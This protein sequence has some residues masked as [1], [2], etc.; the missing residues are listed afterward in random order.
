MTCQCDV[1]TIYPN[2]QH[3]AYGIP[4]NSLFQILKLMFDCHVHRIPIIDRVNVRFREYSLVVGRKSNW[5]NQLFGYSPLSC[6]I[7]SRISP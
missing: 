5:C 4:N 1:E 7:L 6:D 3:L 2:S